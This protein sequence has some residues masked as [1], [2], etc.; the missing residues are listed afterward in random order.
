VNNIETIAK[1]Y[2]KIAPVLDERFRRLWAG[3]ESSA[4]GFG[5]IEI[6]SKATGLSRN[7]IVRGEQELKDI[8]K[9]PLSMFSW[10]N[11]SENENERFLEFLENNFGINWIKTAKIEKS[12]D[13]RTLRL[14]TEKNFISL[15]LNN[16]KTK[17]ILKIDDSRTYKFKI[18]AENGKLS[19]YVS[20]DSIRKVGGGR[21]KS[22]D[23]HPEIKDELSKLIEPATR[24]DPES[25]LMWTCKSLRNLSSE[26]KNKGYNVSHKTVGEILHELGYSLHAN[27]KTLEGSNHP[28]RNKQFEYINQKVIAFQNENQP[29]ISVDAK[30]KENIG[31]FKNN[32][33]EWQQKG[34]YEEVN[35]YDFIDKERGRG[36]PYGVFDMFLNKGWV[37]VGTDNDTSEF[38]VETI[39]RWWNNMGKVSYSCATKL[40]I[41]ADGGGSN[42][43]RVRLWKMELQELANETGMEISVCYF[44]PGTSK[45]NKI[46][47]QL[48]S[49]ITKNWRAKPLI[50]YEVIVNLI[51]NTTTKK[52]LK[53]SCDLDTNQYPKGIKISDKQLAEVN[54]KKEDFHGEWNYTICPKTG[55]IYDHVIS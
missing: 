44:P 12:D 52:G 53:V 33:R 1:R 2:E 14:F 29:V 55:S 37:S 15:K 18:K 36:V 38:A 32:G 21:K 43:S 27:R 20:Q 51:A 13:G 31:N 19:I 16:D 24:C 6:V 25:P 4:I 11:N 9:L 17:L 42:G 7:T 5:G 54:I 47:H 8:E 50:S 3:A 30:K 10:E 46:E 48:F 34:E 41:T 23:I 28:D 26:L 22:I 39:R 40:L 49:F 35:I 45:W